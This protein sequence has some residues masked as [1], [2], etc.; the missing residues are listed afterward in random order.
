MCTVDLPLSHTYTYTR[1]FNIS[2]QFVWK[3]PVYRKMCEICPGTIL[4][5]VRLR[6]RR[7]YLSLD[8]IFKL[9]I[10]RNY[11]F[12]VFESLASNISIINFISRY[13]ETLIYQ[14]YLD[15]K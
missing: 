9:E 5:L 1:M 11:W 4:Y 10:G 14:S 8:Q 7:Y 2:V 13:H 6:V 3:S 15:L 12:N